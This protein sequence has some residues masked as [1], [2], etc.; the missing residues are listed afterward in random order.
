MQKISTTDVDSLKINIDTFQI[1]DKAVL[2][3]FSL[4][5][6]YNW[7][8]EGGLSQYQYGNENATQQIVG[9]VLALDPC[10]WLMQLRVKKP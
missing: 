2:L 8:R 6:W 5:N 7:M 9:D 1:S 10:K 3:L 4:R